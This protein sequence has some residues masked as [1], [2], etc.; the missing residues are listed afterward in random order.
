MTN[1]SDCNIT[2]NRAIDNA[3]AGI[4]MA[5]SSGLIISHNNASLN[6]NYGIILSS[7]G[8]NTVEE[9]EVTYNRN[10]GIQLSQSNANSIK[11]NY[12]YNNS[13]G[14]GIVLDRSNS[15]NVTQNTA[16]KNNVA[17]IYV[18]NSDNN[19]ID[20]NIFSYNTDGIILDAGF[21]QS[22]Q[23]NQIMM[24]NVSANDMV[25]ILIG[26]ADS[27]SI[28][29]NNFIG[30][31]VQAYIGAS[32]FN[33]NINNDWNNTALGNYWSDYTT[34]YPYATNDGITWN[35]PR[36]IINTVSPAPSRAYDYHPLVQQV[37]LNYHAPALTSRSVSPV[38]GTLLTSFT[39]RV[40]YTDS[41][42]NAP[43][44]ISLIIAGNS[45]PLQKQT[46]GDVNYMDGCVYFRT[47]YLPAGIWNFQFSCSDTRFSNA[48]LFSSVTVTSSNIAVPTLVS[49]DVMPGHGYSDTTV[50]EFT[51]IYTD[52]DNNAPMAINV[53]VSSTAQNA[54]FAMAKLDP[55]D[56]NY[57]DGCTYVVRT[58]LTGVANYTYQYHAYD[59]AFVGTSPVYSGLEV[60]PYYPIATN[61]MQCAYEGWVE[62]NMQPRQTISTVE[63][64]TGGPTYFNVASSIQSR[65]ING[66]TR[67]ITAISGNQTF[68]VG[69]HEPV[70]IF[71]D[72][73]IGSK[74]LIAVVL[75]QNG[76]QEFT[77]TGETEIIAMNRLFKCWVLESPSGS[78]VY[79]DTYSGVLVNGTFYSTF[80]GV[81]I[82]YS[83][84]L[85]S[86]A[87]LTLAPN[88]HAPALDFPTYSP[89]SGTQNT[90]F[91]FR[92][93]YTDLDNLGPVSMNVTING[94]NY[95]M[96]KQDP[97]DTTYTDGCVY[98]YSTYL[99]PG[100]YVYKFTT[101]DG[102]NITTTGTLT[103]PTV[104]LSNTRA[105]TLTGIQ[106]NPPSGYNGS[107]L[108]SFTITYTDLDNNAPRWLNMTINGTVVVMHKV[109]PF[110]SSYTNGCLYTCSI[111]LNMTGRYT[112]SFSTTDGTY[113]ASAGPYSNIVVHKYYP[114]LPTT[115]F[116]NYTLSTDFPTHIS[117]N[118]NESFVDL[119]GG[120]VYIESTEDNRT[121]NVATREIVDDHGSGFYNGTHEPMRIFTN[122]QVGSTV[123]I[124]V[125][126]YGDQQF[127]ITGTA[128][129]HAMN[130]PFECWVLESPEGS[131]AYYEKYSGVLVNGTFYYYFLT[132]KLSYSIVI[133]N[134]SIP[135]SP[136]AHDP[137]LFN[138]I[139]NPLTGDQMDFFNF[140]VT[141]RD[142]D[143]NASAYVRLVFNG[144]TYT[145]I[146]NDTGDSN[147]MDGCV[148]N[149]TVSLLQPGNY[150]YRFECSDGLFSCSTTTYTLVVT[151]TN[152]WAPALASPA[153]SPANGTQ[154]PAMFTFRITYS[155]LE[156]NAPRFVNMTLN[157]A[158]YSMVKSNASDTNYLD[159]CLY[160]VSVILQPGN[161]SYNFTCADSAFQYSTTT[162]RLRV[163]VTPPPAELSP[164]MV[165]IIAAVAGGIVLI[166]VIAG[167][168]KKKAKKASVP[169]Q[170]KA[171][172][173]G[174]EKTTKKLPDVSAPESAAVPSPLEFAAIS[175]PATVPA[176]S[177]VPSLGRFQ[178]P[179]CAKEYK[180]QVA[181]LASHY[182]CPDCNQLLLRLVICTKCGT[183]MSI[184]Q[185]KFP[186]Y[187][188]KS[189][190]C[191]N[192]R[193]IFKV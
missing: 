96:V 4:G 135:L 17:G 145:M 116:Y 181:D 100:S 62:N 71:T 55:L 114:I 26:N 180:F 138:V 154:G 45:Y 35:T 37:T 84:Q 99:Q 193:N 170:Q 64:F 140:Y 128:F 156:N 173:K 179:S 120:L 51:V 129:L 19:I 164:E 153:V 94:T 97:S 76:D 172:S 185:E 155:D 169:K 53:T 137:E 166:A 147:Y 25:G 30:N 46:P 34:Q 175:T 95:S 187:V 168:S 136:N 24:N 130:R 186:E 11:H 112:Y 29:L 33:F 59:G 111:V 42:N 146:K 89:S 7:A 160:I 192:C 144:V 16:S 117:T 125:I 13:A 20:G 122:V 174:R 118:H 31:L 36:Y 65:T 151:E 28:T 143:N 134:T 1:S 102:V 177:G 15:N 86:T 73:E 72:V 56:T 48:T 142:L 92:V 162:Y 58:K 101:S 87:V 21:L 103:G 106:A 57:V 182:T 40:T 105:P 80:L 150:P 39:F 191:T 124:S 68:K 98:Q 148:F 69:S 78:V 127:T 152:N 110:D 70:R 63:I 161:Y 139:V 85:T 2:W 52:T 115:G 60:D 149:W 27:N 176:G 171:T 3:L 167:A 184:T 83:I 165:I 22:S 157:G 47:M 121:V 9:N 81:N 90:L 190:Q 163:A 5:S 132:I 119:G 188:G 67:V 10:M 66:R 141:Y 158:V 183:P 133:R 75:E 126:N 54:T 38:T 131:I 43:I 6:E 104:T 12:V 23:G 108:F 93:T 44:A 41:D 91:T 32:L 159:G 74:V 88:T 123:L 14:H 49:G 189:L 79:Y 107:T 61:G 8:G 113:S 82:T 50:F 178:C 77:V 18:Y 109:D